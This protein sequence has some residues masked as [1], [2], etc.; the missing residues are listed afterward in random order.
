MG[1]FVVFLFFV[2]VLLISTPRSERGLALGSM[3]VVG[4]A[5]WLAVRINLHR[6]LGG[7]VGAGAALVWEYRGDLLLFFAAAIV[8]I[9]PILM[10]YMTV[11]DQI[12]RHAT[13]KSI[14]ARRSLRGLG[15]I[16]RSEHPWVW[17]LDQERS[18]RVASQFRKKK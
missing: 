14:R 10:I 5:I 15:L 2:A 16:L 7:I 4:T 12:D 3:L 18:N 11:C 6:I 1:A 8:L 17:V 9:V 13:E